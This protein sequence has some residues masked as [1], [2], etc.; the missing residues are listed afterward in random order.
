METGLCDSIKN[1]ALGSPP[2]KKK[3][4]LSDTFAKS[5]C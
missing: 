5:L 4:I 3:N 1:I 2:D